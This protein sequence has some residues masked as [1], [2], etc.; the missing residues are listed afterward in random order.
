MYHANTMSKSIAIA[1]FGFAEHTSPIPFANDWYA[2][3]AK[4]VFRQE[5]TCLQIRGAFTSSQIGSNHTMAR[6]KFQ[7]RKTSACI[8]M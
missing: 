8:A 7:K 2:S 3:I 1:D 5:D 4:Q 6:V